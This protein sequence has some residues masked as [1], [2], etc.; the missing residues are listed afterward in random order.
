LIQENMLDPKDVASNVYTLKMENDRVRVFNATFEPGEK[1][2]MHHHPDH[3]VY[4]LEG[5]KMKLTSQG[6]TDIFDLKSGDVLF[7]N[8]Q[9][10][11]AE[12][13]GETKLAL[14]VVELKK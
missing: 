3:V 13:I 5:G 10:H 8:T 2:V 11:E 7:L 6:K 12:N 14:L 1:A 4:V 9:S